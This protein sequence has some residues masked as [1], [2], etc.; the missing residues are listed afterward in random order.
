M[1]ELPSHS[2]A[3]HSRAARTPERDF[4]KT[5]RTTKMLEFWIWLLI[6]IENLNNKFWISNYPP[7]GAMLHDP[8]IC[9]GLLENGRS[10][11]DGQ[12]RRRIVPGKVILFQ[13]YPTPTLV[14]SDFP[15]RLKSRFNEIWLDMIWFYGIWYDEIAT[16]THA[17]YQSPPGFESDI[18]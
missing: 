18:H 15:W 6:W 5:F 3:S 17:E 4:L 1:K 7:V 10:G 11:K 2:R 13:E 12:L 14:S 16:I 9:I 8:C